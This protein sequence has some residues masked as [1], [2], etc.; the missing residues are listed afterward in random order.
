MDCCP[1]EIYHE[2]G[3]VLPRKIQDLQT[4]GNV[5]ELEQLH[6]GLSAISKRKGFLGGLGAMLNKAASA[7]KEARALA[8][9]K[10]L[11]VF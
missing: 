7:R 2:L 8:I 10:V 11:E 5:E 3:K 6:A 1:P 4:A 9:Q